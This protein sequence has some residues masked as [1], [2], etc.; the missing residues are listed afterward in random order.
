[1]LTFKEDKTIKTY[2]VFLEEPEKAQEIL[3]EVLETEQRTITSERHTDIYTGYGSPFFKRFEVNLIDGGIETVTRDPYDSPENS[4]WSLGDISWEKITYRAPY[5]LALA[6][7]DFAFG[8]R[9]YSI[10]LRESGRSNELIRVANNANLDELGLLLSCFD[11]NPDALDVFLRTHYPD[12]LY[13]R[14]Y[15]KCIRLD[16]N[17][18]YSLDSLTSTRE[19]ER[20][21]NNAEVAKKLNLTFKGRNN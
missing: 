17:G 20:A 9:R 5:T 19:L 3:K 14:R 10:L 1:M 2:N 12:L 7:E 13:L 18:E 21:T 16:Q 6:A 8:P 11:N 4:E 15:L